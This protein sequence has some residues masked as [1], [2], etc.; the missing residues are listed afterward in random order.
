MIR[1]TVLVNFV[2]YFSSTSGGI[3]SICFYEEVIEFI[4]AGIIEVYRCMQVYV[5][6]KRMK[7]D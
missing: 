2:V 4:V 7:S 1:L 5:L 3:H 6:Q